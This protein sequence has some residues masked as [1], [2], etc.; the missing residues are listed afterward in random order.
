MREHELLERD[1]AAGAVARAVDAAARVVN[2]E[3]VERVAGEA[4]HRAAVVARVAVDRAPALEAGAGH[5]GEL[6]LE[7]GLRAEPR[8]AR[9]ALRDVRLDAAGLRVGEVRVELGV[10]HVG[11]GSVSIASRSFLRTSHRIWRTRCTESCSS[12]AI[13]ACGRAGSS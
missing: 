10:G 9:G 5:G 7:R 3:A 6:E 4:A 1:G 12:A 8:Q 11:H 2:V 13:V